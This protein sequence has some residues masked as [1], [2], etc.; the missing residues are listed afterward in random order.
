MTAHNF[1][2]GEIITAA[3]LNSR[4]FDV[5]IVAGGG[6]GGWRN[7]SPTPFASAGG[8]GG[9]V[10]NLRIIPA[11]NDSWV[12]TI[13]AGGAGAA[14]AAPAARASGGNG[15]NTTFGPITATGAIFRSGPAF[16][17]TGGDCGGAPSNGGIC[18]YYSIAGVEGTAGGGAA[19]DANHSGGGAGKIVETGTGLKMF[20][21]GGSVAPNEFREAGPANT[22][23]GGGGNAG[24]GAGLNGG[25]GIVIVAYDGP[26]KAT[27]GTITSANGRTFHEF[28]SGPATFTWTG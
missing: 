19:G 4:P 28:T 20:G 11:I 23:Y 6:G 24:S 26:Q 13:G 2:T 17:R 12:I 25:S 16:L 10:K 3:K 27:G 14:P 15:G 1:S 22:G 5:V 18:G 8:G 7:P 21:K 9:E